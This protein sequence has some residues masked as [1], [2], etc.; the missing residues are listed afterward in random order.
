MTADIFLVQFA[1]PLES[2]GIIASQHLPKGMGNAEETD[3]DNFKGLVLLGVHIV[4]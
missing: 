2:E 4:I 1:G 3:K